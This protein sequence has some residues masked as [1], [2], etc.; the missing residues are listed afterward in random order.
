MLLVLNTLLFVFNM[1]PLP[2]LDGASAIGGILPERTALAI[3]GFL[4]SP[5]FSV[6]GI[7]V[8]WQVFPYFVRPFFDALLKVVHP[9]DRYF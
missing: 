9:A 5:A 8:A 7:F 3:R 1:L 2:P 4:S 6:L